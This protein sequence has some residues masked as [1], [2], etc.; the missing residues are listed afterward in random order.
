VGSRSSRSGSLGHVDK[1]RTWPGTEGGLL[2]LQKFYTSYEVPRE[3]VRRCPPAQDRPILHNQELAKMRL[4]SILTGAAVALA[5]SSQALNILLN[6][7]DGFGSGN[8]RELYRLLKGEG[9]DGMVPASV[10]IV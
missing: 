9:H 8:L 10:S 3:P 5:S 2:Q 4:S 1:G 6:N 7:D